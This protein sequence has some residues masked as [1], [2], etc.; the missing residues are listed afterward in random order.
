MEAWQQGE[1]GNPIGA[2][3]K[4]NALRKVCQSFSKQSMD[5]LMEIMLNPMSEEKNRIAVAKFI[6]EQGYGKAPQSMEFKIT[7]GLSPN[8]MSSDQ[9]RMFAS[10]KIQELIINL[11]QTGKL[12]EY[13]KSNQ[14][15]LEAPTVETIEA[16]KGKSK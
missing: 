13:L 9:L 3:I 15:S 11:H 5:V 6:L 14:L 12:D 2:Q 7:E 10:G 8:M 16:P 1:F 4:V